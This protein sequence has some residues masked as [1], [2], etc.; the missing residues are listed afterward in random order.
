MSLTRVDVIRQYLQ[1]SKALELKPSELVL[2]AGSAMVLLGLRKYTNDLDVSVPKEYF[3]KLKTRKAPHNGLLG[4][5]VMWD[6]LVDITETSTKVAKD[7]VI[8]IM[9]V[10]IC[11]PFYLLEQKK[12]LV[13]NPE[14]KPEKLV[15]DNKDIKM[16]E[17]LLESVC[18]GETQLNGTGLQIIKLK[19]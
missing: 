4:E 12:L 1:L 18:K 8:S 15:Q 13:A 7:G 19:A 17:E 11:H 14:R 3:E 2:N 10:Y 6:G 9:G 16:L 5:Y